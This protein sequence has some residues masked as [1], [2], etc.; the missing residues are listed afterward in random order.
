MYRN[1]SWNRCSLKVG[2]KS[3]KNI[4]KQ[5]IFSKFTCYRPANLLK[6]RTLSQVF[7][8]NLLK[9]SVDSYDLLKILRTI[10]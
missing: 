8:K 6:E 1:F 7:S 5:F 10:T 2:K 3:V 4:V 9:F